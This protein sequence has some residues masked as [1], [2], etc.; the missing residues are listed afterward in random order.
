MK[1]LAKYVCVVVSL[2]VF[3]GFCEYSRQR[4]DARRIPQLKEENAAYK[5]QRKVACSQGKSLVA[6]NLELIEIIQGYDSEFQVPPFNVDVLIDSCCEDDEKTV[7]E[8]VTN[9]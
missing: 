6:H 9:E 1:S 5:E 3:F 2:G 7:E 8:E 4:F